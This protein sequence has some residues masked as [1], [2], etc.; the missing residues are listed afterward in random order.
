MAAGK[1]VVPAE[2]L[3]TQ[4]V[5]SGRE[6][7]DVRLTAVPLAPKPEAH[8][9]QLRPATLTAGAMLLLAPLGSTKDTHALVLLAWDDG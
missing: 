4:T 7:V 2:N 9:Q 6:V 8:R 1:V 3:Q 5:G